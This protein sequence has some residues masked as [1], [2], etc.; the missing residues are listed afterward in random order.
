MEVFISINLVDKFSMR[1]NLIKKQE[2]SQD[3]TSFIKTKHVKE[4]SDFHNLGSN[5]LRIIKKLKQE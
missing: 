3:G 5:F 4:S 2:Y 1:L